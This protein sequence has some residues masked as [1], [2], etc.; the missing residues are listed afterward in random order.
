MRALGPAADVDHEAPALVVG[1]GACQAE[2]DLVAG[3]GRREDPHRGGREG[4]ERP[5]ADPDRNERRGE[6]AENAHVGPA[7]VPNRQED[8]LEIDRV[9]LGCPAGKA[10]D[11]AGRLVEDEIDERR[12]TWYRL[13][14]PKRVETL[15]L[16]LAGEERAEPRAGKPDAGAAIRREV[17]DEGVG[18]GLA[19]LARLDL[20]PF[21]CGP[22]ASEPVPVRED[23]ARRRV[24]HA[25]HGAGAVGPASRP[26]LMRRRA[27]AGRR[28]PQ[29]FAATGM[30]QGACRKASRRRAKP[31]VKVNE[32]LR[33]CAVRRAGKV[34]PVQRS[35]GSEVDEPGD[36]TGG[37]KDKRRPVRAVKAP[38]TSRPFHQA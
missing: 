38:A 4:D 35:S 8:H 7:S 36:P 30:V 24:L 12:G 33:L 22:L 20:A 5:K 11:D 9:S 25:C 21:G 16:E 15:A 2:L 37:W 17:E 1:G 23:H 6:R 31:F 14:G 3:T 32:A 26:I 28:P 10:G 18:E 27:V 13:L 34:T 29:L 19:D